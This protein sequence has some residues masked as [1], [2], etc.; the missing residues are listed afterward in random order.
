MSGRQTVARH[1]T[2][3]LQTDS[4]GLACKA[5]GFWVD[6]WR[7]VEHAVVTHAHADHARPG[8]ARYLAA[9]ASVPMLRRRLGDDAVIEGVPWGEPVQLGDALVSFHPAGHI[10][11]SAQVRIEV[12]GVVWVVSGDYKR[13]ADPTCETFEVVP[14]DVFVT[15]ATFGLPIYRWPPTDEVAADVLDWWLDCRAHDRAAVLFCYALGKAQ[16]LLAEL[17]RQVARRTDLPTGFEPRVF[18]HGALVALTDLYRAEGVAMLD[19]VPVADTDQG[20]SF[21]GAL[22]LAPP[23]AGGSTWMR[24]FGRAATG[25]ASGWMRVRGM[26]R[27]RSVDRGFILS[28]HADWP[29][30]LRTI[31]ETGA[32]RVLTTHGQSAVLARYLREA[33]GLEATPLESRARP[34]ALDA[35]DGA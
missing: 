12:D 27:R 10:R 20:T 1:Q 26:R 28:D 17:H 22:V 15:E 2:D 29:G 11:G 3:L 34:N 35:D 32:R 25:F 31:E 7:P 30:L 5:G 9:E 19:T 13:D 18:V 6:P 14:C 8:S 16:R 24:R 4:H 23:S 21:A 33:H